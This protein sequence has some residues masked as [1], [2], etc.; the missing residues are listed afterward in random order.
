MCQ[1]AIGNFFGARVGVLL[2]DLT[3]TRGEPSRFYSS[4]DA[5]RG[6]CSSCG[7]P[8]FYHGEGSER[9]SISIGAVGLAGEFWHHGGRRSGRLATDKRNIESAS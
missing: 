5:A 3:W 4:K 6:F 8:L 9:I 2:T 1:K 7:T